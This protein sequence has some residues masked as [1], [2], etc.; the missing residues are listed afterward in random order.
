MVCVTIIQGLHSN[1]T[2]LLNQKFSYN[3]QAKNQV[4]LILNS[5]LTAAELSL[6]TVLW[7]FAEKDSSGT[8]LADGYSHAKY[9]NYYC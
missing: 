2:F 7:T 3:L 5:H 6:I 8:L 9:S 4:V 1:K